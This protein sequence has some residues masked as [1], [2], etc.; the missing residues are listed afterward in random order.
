MSGNNLKNLLDYLF[1]KAGKNIFGK[2]F[3]D[4]EKKKPVSDPPE[5]NTPEEQKFINKLNKWFN[6]HLVAGSLNNF[7]DD[8]N[9]LMPVIKS[10]KYPEL[11]P[12]AGKVYRGM[13]L[14]PEQLKEFLGLEDF[15]IKAGKYQVIN[16]VGVLSPQRIKNYSEGKPISSWSTN[17]DVA[18]AFASGRSEAGK[19]MNVLFVADT[20]DPANKFFLNP[21]E[22]TKSYTKTITNYA[23]EKEVIAVGPVKFN[24][25]IVYSDFDVAAEGTPE[26]ERLRTINAALNDIVNEIDAAMKDKSSVIYTSASKLGLRLP[27]NGR[28]IKYLHPNIAANDKI[29]TSLATSIVDIIKS[30]AAEYGI[31]K[32]QDYGDIKN[33]LYVIQN[34][35]SW[36]YYQ[37]LSNP[38]NIKKFLG[39]AIRFALGV[40]E[41]AGVNP[42]TLAKKERR[43]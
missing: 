43:K 42:N 21:D 2:S 3:N 18:S 22:M 7:A 4:P 36:G 12:P 28:E 38:K 16:K 37:D 17:A 33:Y 14:S 29:Y 13:R 19:Y 30:V 40:K 8:I 27:S 26:A 6:S 31:K 25:V 1:E 35:R 9:E 24:S 11:T 41:G 5:K 32:L 39:P 34:K 20:N 23:S 15:S 10:G